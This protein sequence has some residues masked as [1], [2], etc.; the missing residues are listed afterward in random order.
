MAPDDQDALD[1]AASG[2]RLD[3]RT[4]LKIPFK[5]FRKIRNEAKARTCLMVITGDLRDVLRRNLG[6]DEV[7][8]TATGTQKS[9]FNR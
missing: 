6:T 2:A 8:K 7:I 1:P 9:I 5:I 4:S 3:R